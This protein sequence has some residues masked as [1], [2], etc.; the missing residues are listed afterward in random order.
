MCGK[1]KITIEEFENRLQSQYISNK[2]AT[3]S[4]YATLIASALAIVGAF[5]YVLIK[6]GT[7]YNL[8]ALI[9]V[10]FSTIYILGIII[11]ISLFLGFSQR[12]EQFRVLT[13]IREKDNIVIPPEHLP[14]R[15]YPFGKK[16]IDIAQGLYRELVKI[17]FLTIIAVF[18]LFICKIISLFMQERIS[19]CCFY[20]SIP[21]F[22]FILPFTVV[23][24]ILFR[25][26]YKQ[27]VDKYHK[28]EGL[29]QGMKTAYGHKG[30]KEK[31]TRFICFINKF[32]KLKNKTDNNKSENIS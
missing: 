29:Y 15:Y 32:L 30:E 16:G 25:N 24:F 8:E 28:L 18:F 7:E 2:S 17:L 9:I 21:Y 5:G 26:K 19:L 10:T 14:S 22:V 20:P 13:C 4:S 6:T 11:Y 1:G 31:E 12:Y 27:L 23:S 3:F